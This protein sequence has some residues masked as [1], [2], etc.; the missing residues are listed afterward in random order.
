MRVF[1]IGFTKSSA[2]SFFNRLADAGVKRLIDV[3]LNNASQLAGFAKKDDLRYF[4]RTICDIDYQHV[5]ALAP[6]KEMFDSLKKGGGRWQDFEPRFVKLMAERKI[7]DMERGF[8]S[9]GCLLCAE[10][11]PDHCHRRIVAEYLRRNWGD[12]EI[13]HL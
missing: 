12:L 1:T 10:D 7:E 3:R 13:R 4:A 8:F 6:T 2:E 9:D 5:L 11:K